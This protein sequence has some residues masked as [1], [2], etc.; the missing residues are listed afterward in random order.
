MKHENPHE[1]TKVPR[2]TTFTLTMIDLKLGCAIEGATNRW[3]GEYQRN[4]WI[5]TRAELR[6]SRWIVKIAS[7]RAG[8]GGAFE[9]VGGIQAMVGS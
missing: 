2:K 4:N 5:G 1:K 9:R 3:Y 7:S 8:I 6:M